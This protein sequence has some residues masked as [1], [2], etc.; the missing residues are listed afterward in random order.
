MTTFTKLEI[1]RSTFPNLLP[2][3]T[4]SW[5]YAGLTAYFSQIEKFHQLEFSNDIAN[6]VIIQDWKKDDTTDRVGYF[7]NVFEGHCNTWAPM[8]EL[9]DAILISGHEHVETHAN[10]VLSIGFDYWDISA[11]RRFSNPALYNEVN[12]TSIQE[13]KYNVTIPVGWPFRNHRISFLNVLNE[14]KNDITIVTDDNQK[15]LTTDLRFKN[16]ELEVYF[17]K[18]GLTDYK[19]YQSYNSFYELNSPIAIEQLPHK[20]MYSISQ[21]NVA[22]ET[23]DYKTTQPY[24]TEKTYK[25]LA[26]ARPFI[27]IGDTNIL[28][29][30][31]E[32]GFKTFSDFCDESYD[33]ESDAGKK[34][35]LAVNAL[36]QLINACNNYPDA[37]DKICQHNQNTFFDANRH[38]INLAKFGKHCLQHIFMEKLC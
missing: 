33:K 17:N 32:Q 30:L 20:K 36:K 10:N 28:K 5:V 26:H 11:W 7:G 14:H 2:F 31:Q 29:K 21:I 38:A 9:S 19:S 18:F 22:L 15:I 12:R 8:S 27:I 25:C 23:T 34:S 35:I 4:Q 3:H 13:A 24:I 37:I 16:L 6:D 1:L